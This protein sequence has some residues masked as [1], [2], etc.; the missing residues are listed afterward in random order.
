MGEGLSR[1]ELLASG[2]AV[3]VAQALPTADALIRAHPALAQTPIDDA[4]LGAFADTILPGR[5]ATHTD[6]GDAIPSGAIAGV[7]GDPGAVEAGAIQLYHDPHVGFDA[8]AP[9]FLADLN[10]RA[11]AQG[12]PFVTLTFEKRVAA[13][14]SGLD[15][16]NPDRV[17][18]EAAAAVPV[19][20]FCAAARIPG[21]T[22]ATALGYRTM[23]YPGAA[24]N[25]YRR[26]SY[27]RRLAVERTRHGS[28][29]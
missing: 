19:T 17:L 23:G 10:S 28:L 11:L 18:W 25:G 3:L 13:V 27:G 1:R 4:I 2:L 26:F 6:R 20:A 24:P 9:P 8:L 7:D 29:S 14:S 12:G 22:S 21:A 16:S 15:F 5:P